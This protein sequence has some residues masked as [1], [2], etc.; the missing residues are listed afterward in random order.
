[1]QFQP[2]HYLDAGKEKIKPAAAKTE[3]SVH[4]C[5]STFSQ[6]IAL[7]IL[8]TVTPQ[9]THTLY[10]N[11]MKYLAGMGVDFKPIFFSNNFVSLC[12]LKIKNALKIM[13]KAGF[14][15]DNIVASG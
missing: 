2:D 13:K 4:C 14:Y 10:T 1:M 9:V 8:T 15:V 3:Q 6:S 5:L 11:G 12:L 7:K